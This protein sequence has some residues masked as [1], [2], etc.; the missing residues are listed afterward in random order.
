MTY[1]LPVLIRV[2]VLLLI[3]VGVLLLLLLPTVVVLL[4]LLLLRRAALLVG[5]ELFLFFL[6]C[7]HAPPFTGLR[8]VAPNVFICGAAA[9]ALLLFSGVDDV[10]LLPADVLPL[11]LLFFLFLLKLLLPPFLRFLWS[12]REV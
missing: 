8:P 1:G 2:V 3:L 11:L 12:G 5:M 9:R 4:L 10:V 6:F 7:G